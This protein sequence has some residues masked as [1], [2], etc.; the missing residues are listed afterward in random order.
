MVPVENS[1]LL[2]QIIPGEYRKY[3]ENPGECRIQLVA[4]LPFAAWGG[5]GTNR[6]AFDLPLRDV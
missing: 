4:N 3:G 1:R 2:P 5:V 6:G